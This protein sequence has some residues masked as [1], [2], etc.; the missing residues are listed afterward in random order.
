MKNMFLGFLLGSL[1]LLSLSSFAQSA[2]PVAY[3]EQVQATGAGR[4]ALYQHALAW[5]EKEF[6]YTPKMDVKADAAV[7]TLRLRGTGKVKTLDNNKPVETSVHFEFVFRATDN[8]YDYNVGA[9][10]VVPNAKQPAI[11]L[12][13]DDYVAQLAADRNNSRTNNDRRV[14]AQASSLASEVALSFR[15]YMNSHEGE[16]DDTVGLK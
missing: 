8:G 12:P 2:S 7:G 6:A 16:S 3:G 10:E 14:R 4:R 13:L 9:F 15:S 11:T 1:L 5:S